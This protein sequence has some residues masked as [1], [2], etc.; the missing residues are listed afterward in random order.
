MGQVD[1]IRLSD[2]LI[3][4]PHKYS[5]NS[6]R[7]ESEDLCSMKI[8]WGLRKKF[9]TLLFPLFAW[10]GWEDKFSGRCVEEELKPLPCCWLVAFTCKE[11][12]LVEW[13]E[14]SVDLSSWEE[15]EFIGWLWG[16]SGADIRV[17]GCGLVGHGASGSFWEGLALGS[18]R[19]GSFVG[20]AW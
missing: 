9:P 7:N 15:V 3:A 12:P 19:G 5:F 16:L 1:N 10:G 17:G 2:C 14:P 13:M 18:W 11:T 20:A 8:I 6:V 4:A